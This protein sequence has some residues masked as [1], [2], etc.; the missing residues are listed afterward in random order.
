MRRYAPPYDLAAMQVRVIERL[1]AGMTVAAVGRMPGFPSKHTLY[2]WGWE[3][4]GFAQRM[5]RAQAWGRGARQENRNAAD[6]YDEARARAF[7][8]QVRLGRPIR[9]LVRTKGWPSR[10]ALNLWKRMRPDFAA[11]LAVAAREARGSRPTPF[12]YDEATADRIVLGCHKGERLRQVLKAPGMPSWLAV[13]R[14]RKAHPEFAGALRAAQIQCIRV[15]RAAS[16]QDTPRTT[17]AVERHIVRGGTLASAGERANLPNRNTL[18]GWMKT[19]PEFARRVREAEAWRDDQQADRVLD[20][21]LR[22]V[23]EGS[24]AEQRAALRAM[25]RRSASLGPGRKRD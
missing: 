17:S 1:E 4:A 22:T 3:D 7:L 20:Q 12:P 24:P 19:R 16:R 18:Y 21:A 5:Q 9:R 2:R 14:W 8:I 11:E 23:A 25:R 10:E 15:K 13:Q 6:L